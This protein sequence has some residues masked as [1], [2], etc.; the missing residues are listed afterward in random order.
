MS[1]YIDRLAQWWLR[2]RVM[3]I[4]VS[5]P[6]TPLGYDGERSTDQDDY[7][8]FIEHATPF[9]IKAYD[10][11]PMNPIRCKHC[12]M[13]EFEVATAYVDTA[14]RCTHCKWELNIHTG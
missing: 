9:G 13:W 1:N 10:G 7:I 4:P 12:K 3:D 5:D 11:K 2:K 8:E 14:I 6:F